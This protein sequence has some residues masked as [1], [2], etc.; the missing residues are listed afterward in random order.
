MRNK[1]FALLLILLIPLM[2]IGCSDD[3]TKT[4]TSDNSTNIEEPDN[5]IESET[6]VAFVG[7]VVDPSGNPIPGVSVE[8][9]ADTTYTATTDVNGNW[10][11]NVALGKVVAV[12]GGGSAPGN[13]EDYY[14]Y[15][16]D[17]DDQL[18]N[19]PDI[20]ERN[21][22]I[23]YSLTGFGTF[24]QE[25]DVELTIGYTDGSGA[26]VLLANYGT[27]QPTVALHP[28]V[29]NFKFMVTAGDQHQPAVGATVYV[30]AGSEYTYDPDANDG[31]TFGD[32][33]EKN[34]AAFQVDAEGY[35]NI[36]AAAQLPAST[37]YY[38]LGAPY[39]YDGDGMF[40]YNTTMTMTGAGY[41]YSDNNGYAMLN[42]DVSDAEYAL[43]HYVYD[44]DGVMAMT[45]TQVA[46]T[47]IYQDQDSDI[48][49]V[50]CSIDNISTLPIAQAAD[51]AI[52]VIFN[53]PIT[54]QLLA[55]IGGPLFVL[56]GTNGINIPINWTTSNGYVYT[57]TPQTTLTAALNEYEFYVY[58]A[59]SADG[60][61]SD[62]LFCQEFSI[63][64]P[65]ATMLAAITPGIDIEEYTTY[66]VDWNEI[67]IGDCTEDNP[68]GDY[69]M[70]YNDMRISFAK[71]AATNNYQ[72]WV[73]AGLLPWQ[74]VSFYTDYNDGQ[75]IEG[76]FDI[77]WVF[78]AWLNDVYY[79]TSDN[80]AWF[81]SQVVKIVVMPENENGFATDPNDIDPTDTTFAPLSLAD[82]FGPEVEEGY[83]FLPYY[84][85]AD[86]D[87]DTNTY[88]DAEG[89]LIAVDE[90]LTD[91]TLVAEYG[92]DQ[93]GARAC[94]G[95]NFI[96]ERAYW[97]D[98]DLVD[99]DTDEPYPSNRSYIMVDL[100][101]AITT[102]LSA[103]AAEDDVLIAVADQMG[104]ALGDR[105]IIGEEDVDYIYGFNAAGFILD[106]GLDEDAA[107][108]AQVAVVNTID[109]GYDS[110][111]GTLYRDS[112]Y[113][114]RYIVVADATGM[115][116]GS[117][118]ITEPDLGQI[119]IV[120]GMASDGTYRLRL[121]AAPTAAMAAGDTIEGYDVPTGAPDTTLDVEAIP[122]ATTID[123]LDVTAFEVD[124]LVAFQVDTDD[125]G[126]VDTWE[127]RTV[128][129][130]DDVE[131]QLLLSSAVSGAMPVGTGVWVVPAGSL[132]ETELAIG[133]PALRLTNTTASFY[134]IQPGSSITIDDGTESET[135]N[136]TE[137]YSYNYGLGDYWIV[138]IDAVLE[139]SEDPAAPYTF[140]AGTPYVIDSSR[141]AD[142]LQ[143]N[144]MDR[145]GNDSS[146]TDVDCD[147]EADFDQIGYEEVD[148]GDFDV[149]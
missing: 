44:A 129:A 97:A 79:D 63:Y 124:N 84:F 57:V 141:G 33:Y 108:G 18:G 77:P 135:A 51:F 92:A 103:A 55:D 123:V 132:F 32:R 91:V 89:V 94:S 121:A 50:Y 110:V 98:N 136:I 6:S 31:S 105:V 37:T 128:T 38:V 64:N 42:L 133:W 83:G 60:D 102:T 118:V 61:I 81:A 85:S 146:D 70:D 13:D 101:P 28:Y 90:P 1:F 29:D 104:F 120:Y 62:A 107:S 126:T 16:D 67:M 52:T 117:S 114:D 4:D 74:E 142:C 27:V 25:A 65:D 49:V 76:Y 53:R 87:F 140:V 9:L 48:D 95:S 88:Y 122:G 11:I 20:I 115:V 100:A 116:G 73:Q 15:Y 113:W 72:V 134:G 82:N 145:S 46:P 17:E 21:F 75:Y 45:Q 137:A 125:D 36:T 24:R 86:T 106:Y 149:F 39:D 10:T 147:G 148:S 56:E 3:S 14:Y 109:D 8:L 26:V 23:E 78:D 54:Q 131:I 12:G 139:D 22:P 58:G 43:I 138:V 68:V 69:T 112:N 5:T 71:N 111:T 40:E 35:V 99:P 130:I 143:V 66:K 93:Y 47:L 127:F 34:S 144:L 80:E 59:I 7:K 96:V 30:V 19:D 119:D 41:Y 2:V